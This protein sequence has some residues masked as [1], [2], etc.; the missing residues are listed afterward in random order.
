MNESPS[1]KLR[2]GAVS[3]LNTKPLVYRLE[4]LLPEA[5]LVFDLP[6][7]LASALADE[8]LDVALVPV[9]ELAAHPEW[10][11]VSN[12]CIGCRG[13]V[14]S[15]KLF[16]RTDP[17]SVRTLALDEGSRTSA[18]LAQVL[19]DELFG[20]RP[21]LMTLPAGCDPEQSDADAVLMIGDRAMQ[22]D[23]SAYTEVWDLGDRWCRWA[24]LPFVFA[25]WAARPKIG[26][27]T[28]SNA[29]ATARD[30][31]CQHLTE[32]AQQQAAEL[33]LSP[34]VVEEYFG[35]NLYFH[36][37]EPQLQGCELFFERAFAQG[38]IPTIPRVTIDDC[39]IEH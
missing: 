18:V 33:G 1:K 6:S 34:D 10:E 19:L 35:R 31:G 3:Y 16:F 24:E 21:Q 36:L 22:S 2:I 8:E 30:E 29:L 14:L 38:L 23:P 26:C 28:I 5:E 9:V 15:V 32:I 39:F 37:G 20:V 11:I 17:Q 13:P 12:A 4:T 25:V 27:Q 7:R